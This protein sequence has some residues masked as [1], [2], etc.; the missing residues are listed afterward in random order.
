MRLAP[1][2]RVAAGLCLGLAWVVAAAQTPEETF[3]KILPAINFL[4]LGGETVE[5]YDVHVDHLSTPRL[6]TNQ[7]GQAVWRWDNDD[8]FGN[9]PPNEN[10]WGLGAFV[11]DLGFPGQVRDRETGTFY[12]YFRDCYDPAT[13]RYCQADPIGLVGG[14]NPYTY[15]RGNPL[16]FVDPLGLYDWIEFV[17]DTAN[18]SAGFGDTLTSGFGLFDTSLTQLAR[19]SLDVD[20]QV[21]QCSDAS[22]YGKYG[23]YGWAAITS[24]AIAARAAGWSVVRDPAQKG[25]GPHF[26][27][28]P[29]YPGS[30][31]PRWHFGPI[32]PNFGAR[33]FTWLDWI[34]G[35]MP[36]RWK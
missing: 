34:K 1:W 13:G 25:L 12:N 19:Q 20:D 23:A 24:V 18:F 28:G 33:N 26:N 4:L 5:I 22:R 16:S 14:I 36:W 7:A 27:W 3:K 30:N 2:L 21:N 32:N 6:I 9:N 15:V 29:R 8:P 10:P 17:G 31:H 11:F 35:G